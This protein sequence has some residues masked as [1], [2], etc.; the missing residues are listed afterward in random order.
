MIFL[1]CNT[2]TAESLLPP[3]Q[4]EDRMQWTN[5]YGSYSDRDVTDYIKKKI[6]RDGRT[7]P[8]FLL[9]RKL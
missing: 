8:K 7:L 3:C 5:C 9:Y 4:G 2:A 1:W 6:S